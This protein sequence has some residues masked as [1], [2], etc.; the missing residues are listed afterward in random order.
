ME[1]SLGLAGGT[2]ADLLLHEYLDCR[3]RRRVAGQVLRVALPRAAGQIEDARSFFL[4][5]RGWRHLRAHAARA[6]R[7]RTR[8]VGA[9]QRRVVNSWARRA[10]AGADEDR[11]IL[12]FG[13]Q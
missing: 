9:R 5:H 7:A 4:A 12:L 8:W 13:L 2:V 10:A 1:G 11:P 3:T 6:R